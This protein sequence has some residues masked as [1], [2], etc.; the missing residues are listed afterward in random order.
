[1]TFCAVLPKMK[2]GR[3]VR[4]ASWPPKK[5][6]SYDT[7]VNHF[8]SGEEGYG[9]DFLSTHPCISMEDCMAKDWEVWGWVKVEK[10]ENQ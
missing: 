7:K 3:P 5:Y 4:R 6:M 1:M 10:K 9:F 2:Q 8:V